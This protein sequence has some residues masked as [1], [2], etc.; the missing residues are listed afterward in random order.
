ML[1][2]PQEIL[3]RFPDDRDAVESRLL[4]KVARGDRQAFAQLYDR[5]SPPLYATAI[6]IVRDATEAQD[7]VQDVWLRCQS[8]DRS[9]SLIRA[10]RK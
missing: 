10:N 1:R 7:I 4:Q 9:A 2:S 6:R 8:T 5:F 3:D